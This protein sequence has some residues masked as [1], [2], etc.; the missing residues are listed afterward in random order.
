[1]TTR[2][3]DPAS[4]DP[5]L[6]AGT[7]TF[8]FTDV[9]GST[10][11][12]ELHGEAMRAAQERHDH[13]V[14]DAIT[15]RGGY[16]VKTM[17]DGVM[18]VFDD[19]TL[20][21]AAAIDA[22]R[23]LGDEEW[24]PLPSLRVRMGLH[25]A[26]ATPHAGDYHGN[27]VNRAARIADT[28]HG[29]QIVVSAGVA[30][31]L[32]GDEIALK[33]LGEHRLRDLSEPLDLYQVV[34]PGLD[35]AFAPL[36]TLE[37]AEHNLPVQRSSF[38]GRETDVSAV[39]A[40]LN[41][42]RLLT[43]TGLGGTGKTRLALHVAGEASLR[44]RDGVRFV[45]L[46]PIGEPEHVV[47]TVSTETDVPP[48]PEHPC[49]PLA[50]LVDHL[51]SR[52]LLLVLDN[53]EHVL[54]EIIRMADEILAHCPGVVILA[55]SREPLGVTGE[56]VHVVSPLSVSGGDEDDNVPKRSEAF[57][58]FV[59]R[60]SAAKSDFVLDREQASDV[61]RICQQ[62]DGIPLA[63]ELAAARITHLSPSEIAQRLER[64][65]GLL[66]SRRHTTPSRHR[67]L[68]ATLDWSY[69]QLTP[70]D[71]ALFQRVAVFSGG[72][73]LEAI[74]GICGDGLETG[75]VL[76]N[77]AS[78]VDK[79]LLLT[80][81]VHG[82]TR[83]RMLETVRR[84]AIARLDEAAEV[85]ATRRR[86]ARWW[87]DAASARPDDQ[88]GALAALLEQ[89]R[90]DLLAAFSWALEAR[91]AHTALRLADVVWQWW[92]LRGQLAEGRRILDRVLELDDGEASEER[93][94]VRAAAASLAF[95][96]S[97]YGAARRLHERNLADLEQLGSEQIVAST[98]NSLAMVALFEGDPEAARTVA[99]EALTRFDRLGDEFGMAFAQSSLGMIESRAA[100][101]DGASEHFLEALRLFRRCGRK[102]DAANILNNLG[103]LETD[104]GDFGRAHRFY[105]GALQLHREIGDDRGV[106]LSLNNLCIVSQEK[107]NLDGASEYAEDALQAFQRIGDRPGEAA[108]INNLA[109]LANEH[110]DLPRAFDLYGKATELFRE[111]GDARG[112]ATSLAN[113]AEA[114]RHAGMVRLAWQ[115]GIDAAKV[116]VQLGHTDQ[117]VRE[118]AHLA[119]LAERCGASDDAGRVLDLA[120][121]ATVSTEALEELR[122]ADLPEHIAP[123]QEAIDAD[124]LTSRERQV[125]ALVGRGFTNKAI[126]DEL[127]ISGRTVDSHISHIRTKL[128]IDSRT[129]LTL[130]AV[131]HGLVPD[132]A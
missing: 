73:P 96:A 43:L 65:T 110:G 49:D 57:R 14:G 123:E 28:A 27:A 33:P 114:A 32:D 42:R 76:D 63:V 127:F 25:I 54:G 103:N 31:V 52:E 112:L 5:A 48:R 64:H 19:P 66:T 83:Y 87:A 92:E 1:M 118:M 121:P 132:V 37:A 58:L 23:G 69:E 126:A 90:D 13:I 62:V 93:V 71:Q 77:V 2:A 61:A 8:L 55:T 117:A 45:E 98:Y 15:D 12:W 84:Y 91:D 113:L 18:A 47:P 11:L 36:R 60:A 29:G 115:C 72:A 82:V 70:S 122:W 67:T 68:T 20:G 111:I 39:L 40:M 124:P 105:E 56:T 86:H 85:V 95:T 131:E 79:N 120:D 16:V 101:G 51:R 41:D 4:G 26:A 97:D 34:A 59:D 30:S 107:G 108:T 46:A 80:D 102:R 38:V 94:R 99:A 3:P 44:H 125:A 75:T 21:I 10:R 78:L 130:W 119:S 17:G 9:E 106:A 50:R 100:N 89:D 128:G 129:K 104:H 22:Q 88:R 116:R 6:P 35:D 109:N 81:E 53:C 24:G 74:E 7:V